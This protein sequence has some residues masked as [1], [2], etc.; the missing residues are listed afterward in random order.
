MSVQNKWSFEF[1]MVVKRLER[2]KSNKFYDTEDKMQLF[3]SSGF[4]K[5]MWVHTLDWIIE[6][7]GYIREHGDKKV[8]SKKE[9]KQDKSKERSPKKKESKMKD[10]KEKPKKKMERRVTSE[11]TDSYESE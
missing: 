5:D 8:N 9:K 6:C 11:D 4:E 7:N 1:H 2:S 3:A 10:I